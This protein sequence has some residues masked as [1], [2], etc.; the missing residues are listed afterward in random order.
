MTIDILMPALSP[1]M[2]VGTLAKWMVKKGDIIKAGDLLAE[3]ETDKAIMEFEAVDE[4]TI[5]ELSVKEGQ[6][7]IPVNSVIAKITGETIEKPTNNK[8][9]QKPLAEVNLDVDNLKIKENLLSNIEQINNAENKKNRIFATPLAR[10]IAKEKNIDL[11]KI[12]GSGPRG[13]IIKADIDNL[14][15]TNGSIQFKTDETNL[16]EKSISQK[17]LENYAGRDYTKIEID[18]MRKTIISRLTVAKQ[19]IPHYY[20]RRDIRVDS[21]SSL[22]SQMNEGLRKRE[23][24]ISINDFIIKACASAL[25]E[26][27]ECNVIWGGDKIIKFKASDIAVAVAIEGGLITPVLFDLEKKGLI[28]ISVEMKSLAERARNKQLKPN[29]YQGGS[30][31]ISSLGMMGVKNFDAVINPPHG[32]IL[33]VGAVQKRPYFTQEGTL[34]SQDVISV[35]LSA[36]HRMI[37]GAI[38]AKFLDRISYNIENPGLMLV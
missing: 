19:T 37:D 27:P 17:V 24:K 31:S 5:L 16:S 14:S 20:L 12:N 33:A 8:K 6:T 15:N 35:T 3:I 38:G 2:E 13:R 36:D 22:R 4:G 18:S 23:I 21:L 29:E 26:V 28:D 30:F 34:C 11:S 1:T 9:S 7:D 10:R 25:Q 32:S